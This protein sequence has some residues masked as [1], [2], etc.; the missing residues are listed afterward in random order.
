MHVKV[1][2]QVYIH[3]EMFS[4]L[5]EH[6]WLRRTEVEVQE[7]WKGEEAKYRVLLIVKGGSTHTMV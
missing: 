2:K 6:G 4:V 1:A 7:E 3:I 5:L